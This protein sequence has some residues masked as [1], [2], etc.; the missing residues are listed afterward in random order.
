MALSRLQLTAC[1]F[2]CTA[3]I[4]FAACGSSSKATPENGGSNNEGSSD[5]QH[6]LIIAGYVPMNG[7]DFLSVGI[8]KIKWECVTH[9]IMSSGRVAADGHLNTAKLDA[10]IDLFVS[11]AHTKKVKVLMQLY[12]LSRSA[13]TFTQVL[14]DEAKR[15]ILV[16]DIVAYARSKGF[17]GVDIN[18]EEHKAWGE[19]EAHNLTKLAKEIK[20]AAPAGFLITAAVTEYDTYESEFFGNLDFI[21]LMLYDYN[22][23]NT[24][25]SQHASMASFKENLNKLMNRYPSIIKS[26][27]LGGIPFYGYSWDTTTFPS[28]AGNTPYAV[29]YSQILSAYGTGYADSDEIAGKAS[30]TK[31]LYNGRAT[32]KSKCEYINNNGYGGV[33]IFNLLHDSQESSLSLQSVVGKNLN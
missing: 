15:A 4:S 3:V 29:S 9:V 19:T 5:K 23:W 32:V 18:Y 7:E 17:D 30:G 24:A 10:N 27:L 2:L 28:A 25:N 8:K 12:S 13:L 22:V 6:S 26:K 16:N 11:T 33:M 14:D 21:N 1:L 31:T 20:T